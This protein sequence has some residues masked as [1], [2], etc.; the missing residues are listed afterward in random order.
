VTAGLAVARWSRRAPDGTA[1]FDG[2]RRISWRELDDRTSRLAAVL[3]TAYRIVAGRTVALLSENRIAVPEVLAGV[4]KAGGVYVGLNFRFDAGELEDALRNAAP[5]VLIAS[6]DLIGPA[7]PIAE[8][9]GIPVLALDDPGAEGYEAL[10]AAAEPTTPAASWP[11]DPRAPACIVYTSGTTG[12]PKGIVFDHAAMLQ[13]ATVACLEYEI[14]AETRYL[15]QI[16]HNSSVNITM[17]PCLVAGAA[18]CFADNRQFSPDAFAATVAARAV[19]HTFL[20]PTQLMRILDQL[21]PDDDRLSSLVT[22]GYGSSPIAPDRLRELVDRYGPVFIQL[23]GMAEIASIGTLLRKADHLR[24]LSD[25]P[26]L[27]RSCGQPSFG[28]DVRIIDEHG[29]EVGPG[30]RGEV[31]FR[32]MHLMLGYHQDPERTAETLSDGVLSSGDI[33]ERDDEGYIYIVDRT[34]NLIIRGGQNI[35]PTEI[36]N[37]LY[38]HPAVLEAAVVGAPDPIWGER[39]VSVVSLREGR[40]AEPDEILSFV[41]GSGLPRFKQP[42]VVQIVDALPKNPVGKIDKRAIRGWFWQDGRAV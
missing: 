14:T 16:P 28:V 22:I 20:V 11:L 9:L 15:V 8:R 23:Y 35:V 10:L 32:G 18:L 40:S 17:L 36:E 38:Q 31:V 42:E 5:S 37:V 3:T 41:A 2:D 34:K 4:H 27:L 39:I 6:A 1:L 13:H 21:G 33:G 7:T 25:T 12:R 24:A 30:E 26:R 29:H 19:T